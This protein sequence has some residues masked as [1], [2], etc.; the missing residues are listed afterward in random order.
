MGCHVAGMKEK[1]NACKMLM[2]KARR[3]RPL[4]VED[5]KPDHREIRL[6]GMNW[7]DMTQET[8]QWKALLNMVIHYGFACCVG[9]TNVGSIVRGTESPL[10]C[11]RLM[12]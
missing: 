5:M 3:K 6:N 11:S 7:I 9:V 10:N 12:V 1:R 4:G 8:D 2:G